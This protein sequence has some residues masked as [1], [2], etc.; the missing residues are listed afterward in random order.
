[1]YPLQAATNQALTDAQNLLYAIGMAQYKAVNASNT[2]SNSSSLAE[3]ILAIP[4]PPID[5]ASNI[6]KGINDTI[7]SESEIEQVI[8]DAN[9]SMSRAMEAL[10]IAQNTRYMYSINHPLI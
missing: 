6:A 1:M 2:L 10:S 5:S 4:V 7:I 8:A 3:D 9:D